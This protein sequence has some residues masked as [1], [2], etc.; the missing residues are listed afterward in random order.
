MNALHRFH[1]NLSFVLSHSV[2]A[3][4]LT[5]A[6]P[7]TRT[8]EQVTADFA[9]REAQ[10]ANDGQDDGRRLRE[11]NPKRAAEFLIPF[12]A[13]DRPPG[14]RVKAIGALGWSSFQEAVP[15]LS[16]IAKDETER[17]GIRA[18]ALNPGLRYMKSSAAV[19]TA[20]SLATDKSDDIRRDAYWV[21]SEHGT[22]SAVEVLAS[23]LGAGDKP[24]R[25]DLVYA[26]LFSEHKRAARIVFNLVDFSTVQHDDELLTAYAAVMAKYRLP[27][28][29]QH[30][31]ALIKDPARARSLPLYWALCYFASFPREDVVPALIAYIEAGTGVIELYESVTEFIRSPAISAES[32]KTLSAFVVSGKVAKPESFQL[33]PGK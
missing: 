22:D 5:L 30:M 7:D 29:Q 14:L 26:L 3:L 15:M 19:A 4:A 33:Q 25:R 28:A 17:I 9:A 31:L 24:L 12:L 8:W 10:T 23:R 21:L 2:A 6:P 13:K 18:S 1:L 16:A 32:K 20:I 11:L 27:E